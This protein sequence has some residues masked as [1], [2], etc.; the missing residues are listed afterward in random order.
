MPRANVHDAFP[1]RL[2]PELIADRNGLSELG[3]A[4]LLGFHRT[5]EI[6][7]V[8]IIHSIGLTT[9]ERISPLG[10]PF[11]CSLVGAGFLG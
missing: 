1:N 10:R 11:R 7:R 8:D 3:Y 2:I 6:V 9:N 4:A 5:F